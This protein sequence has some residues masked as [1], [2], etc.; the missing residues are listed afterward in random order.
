VVTSTWRGPHAVR[1]AMER[2]R[3]ERVFIG[4]GP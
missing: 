1:S 2:M 3:E 4:A